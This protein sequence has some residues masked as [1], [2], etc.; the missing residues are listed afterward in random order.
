V[1]IFTIGLGTVNEAVI[2]IETL[3]DST[4]GL[5]FVANDCSNLDSAFE[6]ISR[7]LSKETVDVEDK[8]A[9]DTGFS[10]SVIAPHPVSTTATVRYNTTDSAP[11]TLKLYSARGELVRTLLDAERQTQGTHEV[12]VNTSDLPG[13]VY[14]LHLQQ[15]NRRVI[16]RLVMTP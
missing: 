16:R 14:M 5:S 10:I 4:G 3:A 1:Q 15:G 8:L 7:E 6:A 13:G 12:I 9:A 11:I 2:Y